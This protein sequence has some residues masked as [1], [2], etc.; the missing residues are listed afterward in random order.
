MNIEDSASKVRHWRYTSTA[1]IL[2]WTLAILIA[3]MLGLGWAM[4]TIE[5]S[6]S[7]PWYFNLHKTIGMIVLV[8][9]ALRILWR[10]GHRPAELP[11][12]LPRWQVT[13]ACIVQ[14]LLYA[15]MIIMPVAGLIGAFYSRSGVTFLGIRLA[16]WRF[17]D[18]DTAEFFFS[19]HSALAWVLVALIVL[20]AA[21]A[22]KHLLIDRD[23]VFQRMWF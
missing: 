14:R 21:A 15:G 10:L 11:A 22:L 7:G 2:H 4:M 16:S 23:Q 3:G 13:G 18:H 9:V 12:S 17:P 20:H 1:I 19:I 6:P 8:L 5:H